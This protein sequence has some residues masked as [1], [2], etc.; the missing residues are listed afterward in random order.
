MVT[1]GSQP[2]HAPI[3]VFGA[4]DKAGDTMTGI[5]YIS[6]GLTKKFGLRQDG[7]DLDI[8][9]Y[10][11]DVYHSTFPNFDG[12]GTQRTYVQYGA[13]FVF[14]KH[15][16]KTIFV[17]STGADG[18]VWDKDTDTFDVTGTIR[19]DNLRIDKAPV[20]ETITP[21]HTLTINV[22]GTNYK[23]PLVLA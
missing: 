21:T 12:T 7:A 23:L 11:K 6:D 4:V 18:A 14:E 2:S 1:A 13:E 22:N 16:Q 10:G 9:G 20:L 15:Y 3:P 5:L 17:G 19:T 8:T